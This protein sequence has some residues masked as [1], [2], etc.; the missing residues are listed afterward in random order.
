MDREVAPDGSKAPLPIYKASISIKGYPTA[1]YKVSLDSYG[2]PEN[3]DELTALEKTAS[4]K[5]TKFAAAGRR[6]SHVPKIV[7]RN[8]C[9]E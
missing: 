8:I 2:T 3:T 9:F 5:A 4:E 1:D 6:Q 7:M